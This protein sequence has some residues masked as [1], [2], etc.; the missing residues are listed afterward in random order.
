MR[1]VFNGLFRRA[2][3]SWIAA[4]IGL[5]PAPAFALMPWSAEGVC[6]AML[7]PGLRVTECDFRDYLDPGMPGPAAIDDWDCDAMACDPAPDAC[8]ADESCRAA[9]ISDTSA[10][11][12]YDWGA[13]SACGPTDWDCSRTSVGAV[14]AAPV[15]VAEA[16]MAV[17]G[18]CPTL[19]TDLLSWESVDAA[20]EAVRPMSAVYDHQAEVAEQSTRGAFRA[21][22]RSAAG[23]LSGALDAAGRQLLG[24]ADALGRV[25]VEAPEGV[26]TTA[27]R[28]VGP[29]PSMN[30]YGHLGL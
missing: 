19:P 6:S 5:V 30:P 16:V 14:P 18:L 24:A 20:L 27:L 1:L 4:A 11:T 21:G 12:P 15:P 23:R 17:V 2:T 10:V 26:E 9:E 29:Q 22:V 7:A 25:A 8:E 28:P 3:M 13:E